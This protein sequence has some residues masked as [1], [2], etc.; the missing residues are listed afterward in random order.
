MHVCCRIFIRREILLEYLQRCYIYLLGIIYSL[1][2]PEL[3]TLGDGDAARTL[4]LMQNVVVQFVFKIFLFCIKVWMLYFYTEK[5][6][7]KKKLRNY[8]L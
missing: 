6:N 3:Y 5:E 7:L 1:R 4:M 2:P 8:I